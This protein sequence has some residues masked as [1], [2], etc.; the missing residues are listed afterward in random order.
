MLRGISMFAPPKGHSS[1]ART[2]YRLSEASIARVTVMS[3]PRRSVTS[4]ATVM[5]EPRRSVTSGA[6]V[7]SEPCRSRHPDGVSEQAWFSYAYVQTKT[8]KR[9][10]HRDS[11][12]ERDDLQAAHIVCAIQAK[13]AAKRIHHG[14]VNDIKHEP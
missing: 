3:E 13:E 14:G 6:T 1:S 9:E 8:C 2:I 5:P 4:G 11:G 10:M 7:T 12:R